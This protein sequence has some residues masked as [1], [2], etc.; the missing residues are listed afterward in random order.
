MNSNKK[1]PVKPIEKSSPIAFQLNLY[2]LLIDQQPKK[3]RK[4][5]RGA[6]FISGFRFNAT[7]HGAIKA[8]GCV[9]SFVVI[10]MKKWVALEK[11]NEKLFLENG[12]RGPRTGNEIVRT[13]VEFAYYLPRKRRRS[14]KQKKKTKK[15]T[16]MEEQKTPLS[17]RVIITHEWWRLAVCNLRS[18][19]RP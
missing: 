7:D 12:H 9:H 1:K 4:A 8:N 5:P 19:S 18:I 11:K 10:S 16:K 15:K 3:K 14:G 13:V 6:W 17:G 2:D